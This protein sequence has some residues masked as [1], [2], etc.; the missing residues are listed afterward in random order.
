MCRA[1]HSWEGGYVAFGSDSKG[2]KITGKGV[3]TKGKMT[4]SDVFYVEQLKYNMLS[5]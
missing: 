3:V 4:F 5:V 2:G 1:T